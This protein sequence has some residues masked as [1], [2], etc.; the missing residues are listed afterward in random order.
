MR[1]PLGRRTQGPNSM[2]ACQIWWLS[3][4]ANFWCAWGA[5]SCRSERPRCWRK[6][7][8]VAGEMAGAGLTG[9]QGEFAP[10]GGAGTM[11]VFAFEALDEA[12]QLRGDGAGLATVLARFGSE[13]FE[14]AVAVAP[15][16]IQQ[17]IDGNHRA[18]RIG[19]VVVAGG[20]LLSAVREFAAG[21]SLDH[22]RRDH[23]I[24]EEGEFF[25]FGIHGENLRPER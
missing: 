5:S 4:A 20:N 15:G 10:Q 18:F 23:A 9:R 24:T 2:S 11:R 14:A 8:R 17:G 12:G 13:R 16:P 25:G 21:K 1:P 7:Y 22:Q 6:R 19:E 3:S